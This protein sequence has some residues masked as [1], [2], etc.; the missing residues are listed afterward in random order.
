MIWLRTT[1]LGTSLGTNWWWLGFR[2]FT[3]SRWGGGWRWRRRSLLGCPDNKPCVVVVLWK[4]QHSTPWIG[5]RG[6]CNIRSKHKARSSWW[7]VAASHH[8]LSLSFF[9]SL[10][11]G[12]K[13]LTVEERTSR[14]IERHRMDRPF[15]LGLFHRIIWS[16]EASVNRFLH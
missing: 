14:Y 9:V 4:H 13:K 6:A 1:H 11:S 10:K 3:F 16:P 15:F 2:S 7:N 8:L 5:I 12:K